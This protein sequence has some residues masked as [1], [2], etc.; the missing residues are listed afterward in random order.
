MTTVT[1]L[2]ENGKDC[3]GHVDQT[4]NVG[5]VHDIN[6]CRVYVRSSRN[7]SYKSSII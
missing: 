1:S 6:V 2:L 5:G 7:A 3:L 4:S